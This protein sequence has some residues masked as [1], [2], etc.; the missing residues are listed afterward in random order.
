MKQLLF[1]LATSVLLLGGTFQTLAQK[2]APS[3]TYTER[4]T[5]Y[6]PK[7]DGS[8]NCAFPANFAPTIPTV[9]VSTLRYGT[10][11]ANNAQLCGAC[12]EVKGPRGKYVFMVRDRCPDKICNDDPNMLD[13]EKK[14]LSKV[15]DFG[16]FD[17]RNRV[18]W[19]VV[20]CPLNS[21]SRIQFALKAG[22][23]QWWSSIQVR[24]ARYPITKVE[25][26]L[27]NGAYRRLTRTQDNY[28]VLDGIGV[29]NRPS[30]FRV[31][32]RNGN[33]VLSA[34]V[35][36]RAAA[37]S[38][39]QGPTV[40]GQRQFPLCTANRA[41]LDEEEESAE[42]SVQAPGTEQQELRMWPNPAANAVQFAWE[43]FNESPI[44]LMVINAQGL[45][46]LQQQV[47]KLAG[48]QLDTR[49]LPAGL[50]RVSLQAE[51]KLTTKQL[52]VQH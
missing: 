3:P 16:T 30:A 7:Q 33:A 39:R 41:A 29:V 13:I 38:Q 12:V 6:E 45:V 10:S 23:N 14:Y 9:A 19:K 34:N 44:Q 32:D 46:V 11:G 42:L 31:T 20:A 37:G 28:F 15:G 40:Q 5:Y 17:G 36:L 47:A 21:S 18:S 48:Y 50:Y 2:C 25:Y 35:V 1:S 51:G 22:S 43:E 8:L 49:A 24:N 26:R 27:S 52:L 4:S